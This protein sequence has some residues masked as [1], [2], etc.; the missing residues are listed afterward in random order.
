MPPVRR[1]LS[2]LSIWHLCL[3]VTFSSQPPSQYESK[4]ER[5]G[6]RYC[7]CVVRACRRV[8]GCWIG[9]D[10]IGDRLSRKTPLVTFVSNSYELLLS[11]SVGIA[12]P[13]GSRGFPVVPCRLCPESIGD[14]PS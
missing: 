14:G 2:E 10:F 4:S 12:A 3:V 1:K 7:S 11:I 9:R 6:C 8:Q 5:C 13:G